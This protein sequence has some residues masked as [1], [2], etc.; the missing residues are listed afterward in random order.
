MPP[1][2]PSTEHRAR[3]PNAERRAPNA[4]VPE[5]RTA[6]CDKRERPSGK[7]QTPSHSICNWTLIRNYN[8]VEFTARKRFSNRWMAM[9]ALTW[10][11]TRYYWPQPTRDYLDPTNIEQQNGAQVGTLNV[12]WVGKLSGL[13]ALPWNISASAFWNFRQGF[14]FNPTVQSPT[15]VNGVA[16]RPS[17]GQIN[18]QTTRNNTVR[19]EN[20]SQLDIR[21]DKIVQLGHLRVVPMVEVF[22]LTNANTVLSRIARQNA[23]NAN[24]VS[25]V[26][27]GRLIRFAGRV[28]F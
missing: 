16:L 15:A 12:R 5:Q 19:Y 11:D 18:V 20:F 7:R 14:P 22:N 25:T 28:S 1:Q 17:L 23:D 2:F 21:V 4:R 10:N 13:Y 27:S 3:T 26:L 6:D 8:G 9:G 24:N